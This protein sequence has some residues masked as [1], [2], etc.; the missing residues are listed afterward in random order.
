MEV[1]A[2]A[3]NIRV[4]P[5]KVRLILDSIRG[6]RVGEAMAVLRFMPS[7]TAREVAKV[8]RSAVANAENNYQMAPTSLRIVRTWADGAP[9]LKRWKPHARGRVGQVRKRSSHVSVVVEEA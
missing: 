3:K 6:K 7:P 1:I 8:V 9:V 5:R 2:T 4:S